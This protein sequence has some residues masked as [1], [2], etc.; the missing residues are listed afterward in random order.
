MISIL[1]SFS[2]SCIMCWNLLWVCLTLKIT[3]THIAYTHS[4]IVYAPPDD[5]SCIRTHM[6]PSVFA[7]YILISVSVRRQLYENYDD[8]EKNLWSWSHKKM[9][10][11]WMFLPDFWHK[12]FHYS[13]FFGCSDVCMYRI[14]YNIWTKFEALLVLNHIP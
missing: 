13:L 8:F 10:K 12:S 11:G 6:L 14:L 3:N 5:V 7:Y 1:L 9:E 2:I 4:S